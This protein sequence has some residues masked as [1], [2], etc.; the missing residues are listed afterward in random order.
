MLD[1]VA[2]NVA[3]AGADHIGRVAQVDE[4][5]IGDHV[6][7]NVCCLGK[8]A[9]LE[10]RACEAFNDFLIMD[11]VVEI[12][13]FNGRSVDFLAFPKEVLACDLFVL[14]GFSDGKKLIKIRI[15]CLVNEKWFFEYKIKSVFC[16]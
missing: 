5:L 4:C 11:A 14:H 15:Y 8:V 9:R 6:A 3:D 16:R 2:D 7:H 13:A 10:P 1:Q 12:V